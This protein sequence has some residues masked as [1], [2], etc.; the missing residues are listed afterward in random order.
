[1]PVSRHRSPVQYPWNAPYH[2]PQAAATAN[3]SF[4]AS[5]LWINRMLLLEGEKA[6]GT[7]LDNGY[8]PHVSFNVDSH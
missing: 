2:V 6:M 4:M 7:P 8:V 3:K 5:I 1:M